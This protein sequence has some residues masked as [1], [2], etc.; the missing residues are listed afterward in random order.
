MAHENLGFEDDSGSVPGLPDVWT[1][2]TVTTAQG[3]AGYDDG[4]AD[5]SSL[6]FEGFEGDWDS[7]EDFLFVFADPR[8]LAELEFAQYDDALPH[9]PTGFEDYEQGWSNNE[10]F[11]FLFSGAAAS[12]DGYT[13]L[14]GSGPGPGPNGEFDMFSAGLG[15]F[16]RLETDSGA[17]VGISDTTAGTV[18][19]HTAAGPPG[20]SPIGF[21]S[22]GETVTIHFNNG[23]GPFVLEFDDSQEDLADVLSH[24]NSE[25]A[26][27]GF[28]D[29]ISFDIVGGAL[30]IESDI[31]GYASSIE[32]LNDPGNTTWEKIG[33]SA[34]QIGLGNG[35]TGTG[36]ISLLDQIPIEDITA[37]CN[38]ASMQASGMAVTANGDGS[39]RLWSPPDLDLL[40]AG[41]GTLQAELGFVGIDDTVFGPT[42]ASAEA[43]EDFDESWP[44]DGAALPESW[45]DVTEDAGSFDSSTPEDFEDF[46]EEW[47]DNEN[48]DTSMGSTTAAVFDS[49]VGGASE[50]FEDFEEVRPETVVTA[51]PGTNR[52]VYAAAHSLV[53]DQKITFRNIGGQL[54]DGITA[55]HTYIVDVISSTTIELLPE[56]GGSAIPINDVG[57]GTHYA[58]ADTDTYWVATMATI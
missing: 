6:P 18:A 17:T 1:L 4:S 34:G 24:L 7:N 31:P 11:T 47:S 55:G 37:L 28:G 33:F 50:A 44:S 39:V 25:L 52:I 13:V 41:S 5:P 12:F 9:G 56:V 2:T 45:G 58:A 19:N 57:V 22:D 27:S 10:D 8:D 40:V 35:A 53:D 36:N 30:E 29:Q 38:N 23:R 48:F 42:T 54:P 16:L 49:G 20:A 14:D 51:D 26:V 46:E 21:D 32:I 43:I 15:L 3:A